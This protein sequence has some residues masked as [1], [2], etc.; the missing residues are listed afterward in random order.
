MSISVVRFAIVDSN[1]SIEKKE[2]KTL[3]RI[4]EGD[5]FKYLT[6]DNAVEVI[7]ELYCEASPNYEEIISNIVFRDETED[8]YDY[9]KE[10]IISLFP[11]KRYW[12]YRAKL[13][14]YPS[15]SYY[16]EFRHPLAYQTG[17]YNHAVY[18]QG[19]KLRRVVSRKYEEAKRV[20]DE[21]NQIL[22]EPDYWLIAGK[23]RAQE[24]FLPKTIDVFFRP[25]K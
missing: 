7:C 15:G 5:S 8:N 21:L 14:Q 10:K 22:A 1:V 18:P 24:K 16:A 6:P 17:A 19:N 23:Q 25:T 12:A 9:I 2:Y 3:S 4:I 11:E 20:I 13:C